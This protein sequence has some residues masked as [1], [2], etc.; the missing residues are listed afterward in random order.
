MTEATST[1]KIVA[2]AGTEI[3]SRRLKRTIPDPLSHSDAMF[4]LLSRS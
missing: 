1:P 4:G 3:G 2:T